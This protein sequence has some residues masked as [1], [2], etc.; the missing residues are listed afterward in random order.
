MTDLA[1]TVWGI[2]STRTFR[3]HWTA[4]E[5]GVRCDVRPIRSRTGETQTES[6]GRV[7]PKRKI[8]TLQHDDFVLSESGAIMAYLTRVSSAPPGFLVPQ[9]ARAQARLDEW[10]S[11][12][13]MELDAHALYLLRRHRYLPEIYGE[14]PEACESAVEYFSVQIGAVADQVPA[15]DGYL[16][17]DFSIADVLM[18]TIVD[19]AIAYDID[20]PGR[21]VAYRDFTA[22]RPAY[23]A[24]CQVNYPERFD[25]GKT[26]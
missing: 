19:G 24:A 17:G 13:S 1:V 11:F 12:A 18:T 6:Y 8:P 10:M 16:L 26:A 7:N 4:A 3:V 25:N 23:E 22:R 15:G 2:G 5:L 21:L 14:A 20:L 9:G